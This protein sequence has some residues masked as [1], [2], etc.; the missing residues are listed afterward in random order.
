[1]A[2][3]RHANHAAPATAFPATP[4]QASSS[5]SAPLARAAGNGVFLLLL[6]NVVLFVLDHVL[7]LKGIQ[8]LYL[9]HARPQW[10]QWITHAFCHANFQHLSMN[11]FNL[12]VFG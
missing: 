1:M 3:T 8:G 10:W 7:H 6:L 4:L 12:C 11:L 2:A 5:A 9:N